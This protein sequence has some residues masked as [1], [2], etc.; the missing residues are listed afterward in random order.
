M[1]K[2]SGFLLVE[3]QVLSILSFE[4]LQRQ[5]CGDLLLSALLCHFQ[6]SWW[7]PRPSLQRV[8]AFLAMVEQSLLILQQQIESS[9]LLDHL[10]LLQMPTALLLILE[11]V[12][13]HA[14]WGGSIRLTQHHSLFCNHTTLFRN[15]MFSSPKT[16]G[17][18]VCWTTNV[19][20]LRLIHPK[21][22]ISC[23]APPEQ[24]SAARGILA[25]CPDGI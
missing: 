8:L 16:E 6:S 2:I 7:E 25:H 13:S 12:H 20:L 14:W 19:L 4:L 22:F 9:P 3:G 18:M 17:I 24:Q 21:P 23:S 15:S 5:N 11:V 1:D 10:A